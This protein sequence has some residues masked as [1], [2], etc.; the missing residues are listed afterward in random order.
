LLIK[1][2]GFLIRD[3]E[4]SA[5]KGKAGY[6]PGYRNGKTKASGKKRLISIDKPANNP[7]HIVAITGAVER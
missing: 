5:K 1:K 6:F 4:F 7:N 2:N 3:R